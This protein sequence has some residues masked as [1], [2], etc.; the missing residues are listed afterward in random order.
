MTTSIIIKDTCTP[1]GPIRRAMDSARIRCAASAQAMSDGIL[2][3][4]QFASDC[5]VRESDDDTVDRCAVSPVQKSGGNHP[6]AVIW[7]RRARIS[8]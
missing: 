5:E 1:Q 4:I 2:Q 8:S 7:E 3:L 6:G